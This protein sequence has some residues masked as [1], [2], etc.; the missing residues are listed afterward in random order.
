MQL[1][2]KIVGRKVLVIAE[3]FAVW[4]INGYSI[5]LFPLSSLFS[6]FTLHLNV[7]RFAFTISRF[8][9][10]FIASSSQ[11]PLVNAASGIWIEPSDLDEISRMNEKLVSGK[12]Y[13]ILICRLLDIHGNQ[14]N[15]I[16]C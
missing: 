6:S 3:P 5:P 2:W 8:T 12:F 1:A 10:N 13:E 7:T 11:Q 15:N 4:I 14:H 9:L 16:E